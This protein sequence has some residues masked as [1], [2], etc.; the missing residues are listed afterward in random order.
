MLGFTVFL[1]CRCASQ[2]PPQGGPED[3]TPPT[4]VSTEPAANAVLVS[5][6]LMIAVH[7]S[8]PMNRLSVEQSVY[9]MPRPSGE[10][11]YD[12]KGSTLM[13]RLPDSLAENQT[14]VMTIGGTAKDRR[15]NPMGKSYTFAFS[16]G[17]HIEQGEIRGKVWPQPVKGTDIWAYRLREDSRIP[18][19]SLIFLKHADYIVPVEEQGSFHL[20]YLADGQYRLFAMAD[21]DRDGFY[22]RGVDRIGVTEKDIVIS[23]TS[24]SSHGWNFYLMA[25]DT[26]RFAIESVYAS[27]SQTVVVGFTKPLNTA[28]PDTLLLKRFR[29][30]E[31]STGSALAIKDFYLNPVHSMEVRLLTIGLDSSLRYALE[32]DT[33]ISAEENFLLPTRKIIN[34]FD[35]G[36]PEKPR[37]E[38]VLVEKNTNR[39]LPNEAMTVRFNKGIQRELWNSHVRLM[40]DTMT[41]TPGRWNWYGSGLT[42][43]KPDSLWSAQYEYTWMFP[44]GKILDVQNLSL[45]DTVVRFSFRV[46]PADSLGMVSGRVMAKGVFSERLLHLTLKPLMTGKRSY[47]KTLSA[48]NRFQFDFVLP[49]QY[50]LEIFA[51]KNGNGKFDP[52]RVIPYEPP[53]PWTM[54]PDTLIVRHNWETTGIDWTVGSESRKDEENDK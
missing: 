32:T 30:I 16:T 35:Y 42:Q 5:R 21:L 37:W 34:R 51:D 25:E 31:E 1:F 45:N 47:Q 2:A 15:Q 54:Y 28:I 17:D 43:Y 41:V 20:S 11:R 46:Y 18:A 14:Y 10:I 6:A 3:K 44:A 27:D 39:I 49:G 23:E 33:L 53:E 24:R 22:S 36:P 38:W 7:F 29:I 12:W 13:V 19:D 50:I 40:A 48:E 4:V 9:F 8:E 52:G 26:V